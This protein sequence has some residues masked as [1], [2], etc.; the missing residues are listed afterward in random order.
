MFFD[1]HRAQADRGLHSAISDWA[2]ENG[3]AEQSEQWLSVFFDDEC[4][5]C[6]FMASDTREGAIEELEEYEYSECASLDRATTLIKSGATEAAVVCENMLRL[7]PA[8]QRRARGSGLTSIDGWQMAA[9]LWAE[10]VAKPNDDRIVGCWWEDIFDPIGLSAPRGV[11]F[12]ETLAS[13]HIHEM[14]DLV[15]VPDMEISLSLSEVVL[16]SPPGHP[17]RTPENEFSP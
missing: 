3:L 17:T 11:I 9:V 13:I 10:D 12:T 8:G 14:D 5:C 6:R 2:I 16:D 15:P 4:D 7:T 1:I